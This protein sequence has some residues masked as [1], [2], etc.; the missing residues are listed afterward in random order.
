[1][2]TL[3]HDVASAVAL[4][5]VVQANSLS[6]DGSTIVDMIDSDGA[7]F[8]IQSIGQLSSSAFLGKFQES[9]DRINWTDIPGGSFEPV[10]G[11]NSLQIISFLRSQRYLRYQYIFEDGDLASCFG[12]VVLATQKKLV[13]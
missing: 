1:M 4:Q 3:L 8:A 7:C 11:L 12:S 2:S 6:E 5:S 13:P 10:K 9:S